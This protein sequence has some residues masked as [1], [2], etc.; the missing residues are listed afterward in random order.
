MANEG[1]D[2][3]VTDKIEE[4]I[5][6]KEEKIAGTFYINV[7]HAKDLLP[8]DDDASTSDPL[9]K[10]SFSDKTIQSKSLNKT[11]NPVWNFKGKID[12]SVPKASLPSLDINVID[13]NAVFQNVMI[14]I[15]QIN[16]EKIIA[17]PGK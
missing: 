6:A 3:E 12:F 14:G 1:P 5:K 9:V 10:I 11:L 15:K 2:P 13:H 16:V 4:Q 17:K 8:V 7:P